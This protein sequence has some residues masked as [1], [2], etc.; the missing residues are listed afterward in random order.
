MNI[1]QKIGLGVMAPLFAIAVGHTVLQKI[2]K[3]DNNKR[4]IVTPN[5]NLANIA[6]MSQ[7]CLALDSQIVDMINKDPQAAER[8]YSTI[9][10]TTKEPTAS[11]CFQLASDLSW[12]YP[13]WR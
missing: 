12:L 8:L 3:E 2:N 13:G 6:N 10:S 7:Q 4:E 9:K 1:K 11:D 5:L